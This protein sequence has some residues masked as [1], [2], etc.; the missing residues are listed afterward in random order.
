MH[1]LL[2]LASLAAASLVSCE[3]VSSSPSPAATATVPP[4]ARGLVRRQATG[5][6]VT[7]GATLT[8]SSTI[9]AGTGGGSAHATG[10]LATL[11]RNAASATATGDVP[12]KPLESLSAIGTTTTSEAAYALPTT[13][14]AG[15]TPPVKGA[16]ALPDISR[17]NP[18]D[19][20]PLD[21]IPPL[22]SPEMRQWLSEIDLSNI[23]GITPTYPGGCANQSN[24]QAV[25]DAGE[26]GTCWWTC[27]HCTRATDISYCPNKMDWGAS[28][29]DGPSPYTPRLLDL[30][31]E[32]DIQATF[33]VVGSRAI[34]RPQMLQAEYMLGHQLSVHTWAHSTLTTLSNEEIV[35]ELAWT[36]KVIKDITGV[37]PNT[38]RPPYGDLDD[39]VRY[40]ALELGLRPVIWTS[41][42]SGQVF[43]TRDWQ[44]GGGV[45]SA[46]DVY[47]RFTTFLDDAVQTL[48]SGFIVLAHDL[49]QQSVDLAVDYVLPSV[50]NAGRLNI[51]TIASCLG[52]SLAD[53]YIETASNGT[54][55]PAG[56]QALLQTTSTL[57]GATGSGFVSQIGL[58]ATASASRAAESAGSQ[59]SGSTSGAVSSAGVSR[60][61]LSGLCAAVLCLALF[62]M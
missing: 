23:P 47:Q 11:S 24:A 6:L 39:R 45:V 13:P 2:L 40:I 3:P 7:S 8:V 29:D 61:A 53:S 59:D 62:R 10:S 12:S 35:A 58:A 37:T 55:S 1:S 4:A 52:Q 42:A 38:F 41:T 14:T 44:I 21:R 5:S 60:T 30:L 32:Q 48:P 36:K 57:A 28:F 49:Y 51:K 43:D 15:A 27:G 50:I 33:F 25:T 17:L 34:S 18:A 22:D 56:E 46:I 20:P 16:P 26:D 19:Y 54:G 31:H 9:R